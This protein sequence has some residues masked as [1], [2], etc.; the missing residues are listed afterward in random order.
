M[1][2]W[3]GALVAA[4][5]FNCDLSHPR[6][7]RDAAVAAAVHGWTVRRGLVAV[8]ADGPARRSL[9]GGAPSKLDWA[10]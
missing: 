1:P 2:E 10:V 4:G 5:D 7:D 8:G 6:D 9:R 3:A